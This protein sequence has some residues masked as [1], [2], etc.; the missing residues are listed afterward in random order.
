MQAKHLREQQEAERVQQNYLRFLRLREEHM[1]EIVTAR[2][3]KVTGTHSSGR[4]VERTQRSQKFQNA[5][6]KIV[7]HW[8]S[9]E[10]ARQGRVRLRL[11]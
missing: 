8:T 5:P 11:A 2:Q 3:A 10:L 7:S 9:E 6:A 4:A 1:K